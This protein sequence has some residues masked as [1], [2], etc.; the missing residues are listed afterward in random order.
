MRVVENPEKDY[1]D[2]RQNF[3]VKGSVHFGHNLLS[4]ILGFIT[5]LLTS[6]FVFENLTFLMIYYDNSND[7]ENNNDSHND[8]NNN[9]DMFYL[10]S[11]LLT[12]F[13]IY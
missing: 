10:K 8:S 13:E 12:N 9:D 4:F 3:W 1:L 11:L 5:F 2:F 6:L 7:D